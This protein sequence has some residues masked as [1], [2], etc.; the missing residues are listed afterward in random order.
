MTTGLLSGAGSISLSPKGSTA[1]TINNNDANATATYSGTISG[2]GDVLKTGASTENFSGNNTGT[3][4]LTINGG[5][6]KN[7]GMWAFTV[8]RVGGDPVTLTNNGTITGLTDVDAGGLANGTG[9]YGAI[10]VNAGGTLFPGENGPAILTGIGNYNQADGGHLE[11]Q[12]GG[13]SPGPGYS[14]LNM[15]GSASLDGILDLSLIDGFHPVLG[16]RFVILTSSDLSGMFS[17]ET[18][19]HEGNVTFT[20]EYS[21]PGFLNDVVL[22]ATIAAVPEPS[23]LVQAM[24][25]LMALAGVS[26]WCRHHRYAA[27][28]SKG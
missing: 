21:P 5:D 24:T 9:R 19:L 8:T 15:S 2:T 14:Q 11:I 4:N 6:V 10:N 13:T 12:I 25:A 7:T 22:E 1:L 20:V 27:T 18:G 17:N 28:P 26:W 16:E 3:G 23:S